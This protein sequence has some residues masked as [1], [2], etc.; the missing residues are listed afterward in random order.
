MTLVFRLFQPRPLAQAVLTKTTKTSTKDTKSAP[1]PAKT[2][3]QF[4]PLAKTLTR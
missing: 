3:N 1:E 2:S 4:A